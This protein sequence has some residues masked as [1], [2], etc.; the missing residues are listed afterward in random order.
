MRTWNRWVTCVLIMV[1]VGMSAAPVLAGITATGSRVSIDVNFLRKDYGKGATCKFA[2][3]DVAWNP[4]DTLEACTPP[5]GGF[6]PRA[7]GTS[8]AHFKILDASGDCILF[9]SLLG[10]ATSDTG[11]LDIIFNVPVGEEI[12]TQNVNFSPSSD[13]VNISLTGYYQQDGFYI[14]NSETYLFQITEQVQGCEDPSADGEIVKVQ[15]LLTIPC[16]VGMRGNVNDDPYGD[17][18]LSDVLALVNCVLGDYGVACP[19][20]A[21]VDADGD[22]DMDDVNYLANFLFYGGPEPADCTTGPSNPTLPPGCE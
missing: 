7:S 15:Q 22:V 21:D 3:H 12:T 4:G 19:E 2:D 10:N 9:N 18:D 13:Y 5:T 1:M 6:E 17:I 8:F 11:W 14:Q 16:C 20:A